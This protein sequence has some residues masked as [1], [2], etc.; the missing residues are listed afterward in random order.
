MNAASVQADAS[1]TINSKI[2]GYSEYAIQS[3]RTKVARRIRKRSL[4]GDAVLNAQV[5]IQ[6]FNR[7]PN[8]L[9]EVVSSSAGELKT[10][11][12]KVRSFG[13]IKPR[14]ASS[15]EGEPGIPLRLLGER[16]TD[17]NASEYGDRCQN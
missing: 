7:R 17:S 12:C 10:G 2:V 15:I 1:D 9:A 11:V 13:L 5:V 16:R 4:L 14:T 3:E 6:V 8:T